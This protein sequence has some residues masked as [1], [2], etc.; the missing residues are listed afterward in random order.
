MIRIKNY[1]EK[2]NKDIKIYNVEDV[3]KEHCD[4]PMKISEL[5]QKLPKL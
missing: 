5:K 1:L 4:I 2:L 3:L